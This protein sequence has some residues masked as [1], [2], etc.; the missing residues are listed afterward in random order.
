[1]YEYFLH[2]ATYF[3][4]E[5]KDLQHQQHD[6]YQIHH[7]NQLYQHKHVLFHQENNR[8]KIFKNLTT[9]QV[10]VYNQIQLY[11]DYSPYEV[12]VYQHMNSCDLWTNKY[13]FLFIILSSSYFQNIQYDID[14]PDQHLVVLMDLQ[15][16]E[17]LMYIQFY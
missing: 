9:D 4:I 14:I 16:L 6:I 7:N 10:D 5:L 15:H 11:Y 3:S 2:W 13:S 1:M 8:L 12:Q 17:L